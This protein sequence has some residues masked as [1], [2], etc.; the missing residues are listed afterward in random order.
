MAKVT[1]KRNRKQVRQ[2]VGTTM[3]AINQD[4]GSIESTPSE[5]GLNAAT[6][7]DEALAF[8]GNN[9]FRGWWVVGTNSATTETA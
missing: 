7:T 5:P 4:D 8:G 1:Q 2:S 3:S 9:E 6:I